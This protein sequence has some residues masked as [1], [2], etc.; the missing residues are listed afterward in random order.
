MFCCGSSVDPCARGAEEKTF[1]ER[2]VET[3][4]GKK[5]KRDGVRKKSGESSLKAASRDGRSS[6]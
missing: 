1:D 4:V 3:Q 6:L 5:Q 2:P